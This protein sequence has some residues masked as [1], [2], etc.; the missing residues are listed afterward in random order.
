MSFSTINRYAMVQEIARRVLLHQSKQRIADEM[1]VCVKTVNAIASSK[2]CLNVIGDL[3][4]RQFE[5]VDRFIQNDKWENAI[6]F[7]QKIVASA[8]EQLDR[9]IAT[10]R[11]STSEK[12][13]LDGSRLLFEERARITGPS[14][15]APPLDPITAQILVVAIK[16]ANVVERLHRDGDTV[17]DVGSNGESSGS[18]GS[19]APPSTN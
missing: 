13:Q 18:L 5:N 14:R 10:L 11:S 12:I 17:V 3:T 1:G 6:T 8:D 2:E 19:D 9:L 4:R 7:E 16:E 15:Q